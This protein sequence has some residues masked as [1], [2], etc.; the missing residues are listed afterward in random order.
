MSSPAQIPKR[1]GVRPIACGTRRAGH[2]IAVAVLVAMCV[3]LPQPSLAD[4]G[5]APQWVLPIAESAS[6]VRGF[7]PPVQRWSA[8]HRGVDLAAPAGTTVRAAG[9]GVVT[10][11]GLLAGRGVVAVSHGEL[12]TTYE[13]V[14]A[15][16]SVGE[17]VDPSEPIGTL[18]AAGGHCLPSACLHWGLLRGTTYLDPLQLL[19]G[20]VRLLPLGSKALMPVG[21][22]PP[23]HARSATR[24]RREPAAGVPGPPPSR[25]RPVGP[26][27]A[28]AAV[29]GAR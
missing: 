24:P 29:L 13:P 1:S 19:G 15:T 26:L 22:P 23:E 18:A 28:A 14:T 11:A 20:G 27:L 7:D 16:V 3:L 5:A 2:R 8:G 21:A 17:H 4:E 25:S 9:A 6:V 10:Y 12:R